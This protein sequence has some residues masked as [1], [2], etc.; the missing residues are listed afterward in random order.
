M[1]VRNDSISPDAL[2][3]WLTLTNTVL[4]KLTLTTII[5]V[6]KQGSLFLLIHDNIA[7]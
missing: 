5:K 4:G 3:E 1:K 6:L 2:R 7:H